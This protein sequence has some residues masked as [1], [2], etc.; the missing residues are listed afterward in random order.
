MPRF[1]VPSPL[2]AGV[3]WAQLLRAAPWRRQSS[4][5][6][7]GKRKVRMEGV[8][9][10]L[11]V[12]VL[13]PE[14]DRIE[15]QRL[16]DLVDLR[17][18]GETTLR[19]AVTAV[20][21]AD[22]VVG[23]DRTPF[24]GLIGAAVSQQD[25]EHA[26]HHDDFRAVGRVRAAV[27]RAA[28]VAG[29]EGSVRLDAGFEVDLDRIARG[30]DEVLVAGLLHAHGFACFLSQQGC[31]RLNVAD[32]EFAAETAAYVRGLDDVHHA[33]RHAERKGQ[34][35]PQAEHVLHRGVDRQAPVGFALDHAHARLHVAG[36]GPLRAVG[37]FEYVIS[38]L[39]P[40]LQVA[41][42][43]NRVLGDIVFRFFVQAGRAVAHRGI[44]IENGIEFLVVHVD[45][46]QRLFGNLR[47]DGRHGRHR[48]AGIA[49]R[50]AH[51]QHVLDHAG[52]QRGHEVNRAE[53]D[54]R[55]VL[56]QQ[57]S[58]NPR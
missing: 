47:A 20:T 54:L 22:H 5:R 23:V 35:F 15:I 27:Q 17:F 46:V 16:T 33:F 13:Q 36:V 24:P 51:D 8:R 50:V 2:P 56:W 53:L 43:E 42:L 3:R 11:L 19:R 21:P 32:I 40:G 58:H 49:N 28:R 6:V 52:R 10:A 44:R 29:G 1:T 7:G 30:G 26:V 41:K 55:Y 12:G 45:Q 38:F 48:L 34:F 57:H 25:P 37:A 39:E 14:L 31:D 4:K 18:H 9:V